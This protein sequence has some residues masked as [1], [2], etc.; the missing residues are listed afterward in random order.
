M[1]A[2]TSYHGSSPSDNDVP[3]DACPL[4]PFVDYFYPTPV[5]GRISAAIATKPS[6]AFRFH[7]EGLV[8]VLPGRVISIA[9]SSHR[10][11]IAGY[12]MAEFSRTLLAL[13]ARD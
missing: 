12:A 4:V 1:V 8:H 6:S 5:M 10:H 2:M 13:I 9:K 7:V 3:P 11:L